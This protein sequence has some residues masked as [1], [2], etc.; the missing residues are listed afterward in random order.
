MVSV[1]AVIL[2]GLAVLLSGLFSG[3]E[4]GMYQLSRVRLRLAL[5]QKDRLSL[6]LSKSL[7]D[8]SGLLVTTLIGTNLSV[9]IAT[10]TATMMLMA[11]MANSDAAEGMAT[12]ITTPI[13]FVFGEL[14]P[15]NLFLYHADTLM[16]L[17]SPV[18]YGTEKALRFCGVIPLLK[19]VAGAL[20]RLT[21]TH[22]PSKLATE[23]LHR[24]EMRGLVKDTQDEG[25]LTGIQAGIMNRLLVASTT[26]IK[27]VMTRLSAVK[28]VTVQQ[29]R[30]QLMALLPSNR[31]TRLLVR[32]Q[33]HGDVLG[34]INITQC[35]GEHP[36]FDDLTE[37]V[38]PIRRLDG[39]MP[40]TS[41]ID[42]MQR[43]KLKI[44]LVTHSRRKEGTKAIGILT[45][46]DLAE[47]LLGELAVW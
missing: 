15:K 16:P 24:H 45:M 12:L 13:L 40:V 17:V 42:L 23:S 14:L 32:K 18:L 25:F 4:T 3:G 35:L 7:A 29:D 37:L 19:V 21:G 39:D 47:E 26:P 6:I 10:T 20:A 41:A 43:E 1:I 33:A 22:N 9:H 27:A 5:A 30:S 2:F 46:K 31:Y 34:Y 38:Q 11:R 44:V 36:A 28:T 8:R